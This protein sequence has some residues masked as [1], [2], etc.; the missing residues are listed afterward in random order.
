MALVRVERLSDG[1]QIWIDP[2]KIDQSLHKSLAEKTEAPKK[3]SKKNAD[4]A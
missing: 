2:V 1:K 3:R 4:P